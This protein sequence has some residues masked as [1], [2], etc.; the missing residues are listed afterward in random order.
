MAHEV[1]ISHSSLDKPVAD[2][3]CAA[4]EKT[5]IRCWLAPRDVQP[6][7]S[8]AGEITRAIQ[9]SKVMV[10][11]FSA[12]SNTSEQILR[13]V[14]LAANSHLHIVQFRIE[15]VLPNEDLE[16][17]L[18]APHWLDALTPPL[19]NN[20]R[21]LRS[22]VK[23]LLEM[24]VEESAKPAMTPVASSMHSSAERNHQSDVATDEGDGVPVK[25]SQTT[26]SQP[27]IPPVAS[28]SAIAGPKEPSVWRKKPLIMIT[29]GVA[30]ALLL[31]TVTVLLTRPHPSIDSS[32]EKDY[33]EAMK[34]ENGTGVPK[35]VGKAI[36][37]Y[38]KAADHGYARA[39]AKLGFLYWNGKGVAKDLS[40]AVELFQK[41][42]DQGYAPAQTSLGDFYQYGIGVPKDVEKATELYKK[43][44]DQGDARAQT[45][46]DHLSLLTPAPHTSNTPYSPNASASSGGSLWISTKPVGATVIVDG[47]ITKI[48]PATFSNLPSGQHHLQII[49][50]GYQTEEREVEIQSGL[51]KA[52]G[53]ITLLGKYNVPPLSSAPTLPQPKTDQ[54]DGV[55]IGRDTSGS[56]WSSVLT[57]K[58]GTTASITV[59]F[60]QKRPPK[61]DRWSGIPSPY[62][63]SRTLFFEWSTESTSVRVTTTTVDA[64]WNEWKL[65]WKPSGIPYSVLQ[66]VYGRPGP[67]SFN[68]AYAPIQGW[69]FTLSGSDLTTGGSAGWTFHR[70]R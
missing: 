5:T 39:Q 66:N 52:P 55:W 21:R 69:E 27:A 26:Q 68:Q 41:A 36:Q 20:I 56:G 8:F 40:K 45:Y 18:S 7:R 34:L 63:K 51:V 58:G 19:E 28:I 9:H 31:L 59:T 60:T 44:A 49:L 38:Q 37:L 47:S 54:F 62:D 4:L 13:E 43:A 64:N 15:N 17:Y 1:F 67:G 12:H 23:A 10:L 50:E 3:V 42:A 35:D 24:T 46:L 29:G 65:K 70:K 2:A 14:Q 32:A 33:A 11:I 16:Y 61:Y 53:T 22:S 48:S 6:G 30:A 25:S 57:I